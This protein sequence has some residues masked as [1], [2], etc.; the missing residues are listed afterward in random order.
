LQ[1]Y[2]ELYPATEEKRLEF[3]RRLETG[4]H[5]EMFIRK[6]LKFHFSMKIEEFG[7]FFEDFEDA[8]FRH[9]KL[10]DELEPNRNSYSFALK[11]S[12]N[13]GIPIE[14]AEHWVRAFR[15]SEDYSE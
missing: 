7:D 6:A 2:R 9:L 5:E 1:D 14:R 10:L 3:C 13:L 12:R 8:R 4:G 15:S 11:V